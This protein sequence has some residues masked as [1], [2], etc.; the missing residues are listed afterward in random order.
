MSFVLKKICVKPSSNIQFDQFLHCI[1]P[2]IL[3]MEL[4]EHTSVHTIN[5]T[6]YLANKSI[7]LYYATLA[8]T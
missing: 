5:E 8:G 4:R 1:S 3:V 7:E 6:K 2:Q